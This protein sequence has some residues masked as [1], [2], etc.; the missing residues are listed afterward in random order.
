VAV[1]AGAT[2]VSQTE[3]TVRLDPALISAFG[4]PGCAD[5]ASL[6][7]TL[8]AATEQDGAALQAALGEL[9][10][11]YSQAQR[12]DADPR[13]AGAG[14]RSVSLA[15]KPG[16]P[17]GPNAG[18][19]DAAAPR[20]GANGC[21]CVPPPTPRDRVGHGH[22]RPHG[23]ESA[24]LARSELRHGASARLAGRGPRSPLRTADEASSAWT[25]AGAV[26]RSAPGSGSEGT[27]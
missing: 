2:A 14:C 11:S 26:D 3:T 6:A 8:R 13:G 16:M 27:R 15:G 4:L 23:G 9:F 22:Y 12:H 24:H 5:P 18:L 21:G 17:R 20:P 10:G 7:E 25:A 19:G 1:L